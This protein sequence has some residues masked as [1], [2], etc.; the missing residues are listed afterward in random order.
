M[1]VNIVKNGINAKKCVDEYECVCFKHKEQYVQ[2]HAE[3]EVGMCVLGTAD[4]SWQSNQLALLVGGRGSYPY[5]VIFLLVHSDACDAP[6]YD[7]IKTS[8]CEMYEMP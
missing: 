1:T 2:R 5:C 3:M 6:S 8:F 4:H 7:A